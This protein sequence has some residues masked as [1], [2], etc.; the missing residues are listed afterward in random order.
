MR[1]IPLDLYPKRRKSKLD[2]VQLRFCQSVV[3]EMH[4]KKHELY[5]KP[6]YVPVDWEKWGLLDYPTIVTSPMDLSSIKKKLDSGQYETASEFEKDFRLMLTNCFTYNPPKD[7]VHQAGRRLEAVF[8]QQWTKL[9]TEAD[10][11]PMGRSNKSPDIGE[12]DAE[13]VMSKIESLTTIIAEQSNIPTESLQPYL[14]ALNALKKGKRKKEKRRRVEEDELTELTF[15]QKR[16]LSDTIQRLP[17][18]RLQMVV[19]IIQRSMPHI[20]E[21]VHF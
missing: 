15:E 11:S 5:A 9:P 1:E 6:F 8:Q 21:V 18:E 12:M 2:A 10:I 7:P 14:D 20:R 3:R 17:L 16:L 13:E 19:A 4:K